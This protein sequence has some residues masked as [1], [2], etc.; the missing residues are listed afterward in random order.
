M[1]QHVSTLKVRIFFAVVAS[2]QSITDQTVRRE[3]KPLWPEYAP[4]HVS[5]RRCSAHPERYDESV[6]LV[7]ER[8]DQARCG[9]H[10]GPRRCESRFSF[11][12]SRCVLQ[13]AFLT[14]GDI[15]SDVTSGTIPPI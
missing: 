14:Y 8:E 10:L 5:A 15:R 3:Q 12:F 13:L 6:R 1:P 4:S 2:G 9:F 7:E 11:Y